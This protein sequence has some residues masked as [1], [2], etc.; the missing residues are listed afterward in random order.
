[1]HQNYKSTRRRF[2]RQAGLAALG[3]ST[4]GSSIFKLN[5]LNAAAL[6]N[7]SVMNDDYKALVCL[8]KSGGNDSFNMLMPRGNAEYNEYAT[9]RSNLAIPQN[10]ILAINPLTSDGKQYGVHPSMSGVQQLFENQ[11]L[12][13]VSNIGT[14]IAPIN[15]EQYFNGSV[16]V[17]LGLFS[18]ADQIQQWQTAHPHLRSPVGWG[19][20]VADLLSDMNDNESISMNVSMSGT[21]VFQYGQSTIEFSANNE[22]GAEGIYGYGEPWGV[23]PARTMAIDQMLDHDYED[24]YQNTYV[25]VLRNAKDAS[26]EFRDAVA[27]IPE[28]QTNF[29]A[30]NLS[31]S[32]RMIA[33][34]IAARDILGFKRQIFFVNVGG[35]DNHDELL[36][37]QQA[38]LGAVSTALSEFAEVLEEIDM[39]D[40]VTTFTIS[41]FG[42]TL[43]SNGNGTDHAWGG[44]VM[45]MGGAV[46]GGEMFGTFPSLELGN[47]LEIYG[48]V[49][50]PTTSA[51]LYFAELALWFGVPASELNTIFP[52]LGNFY[53]VSG[54]GNP[55][56]LIE[57]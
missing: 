29:S 35:W 43:T 17:P 27:S 23:D 21:N 24:I 41:E 12:S 30:G 45:A 4:V 36:N 34:A 11:K 15:K 56:G 52:N 16:P 50:L 25:N 9:T 20:R 14:M 26:I 54:G 5:A 46:N 40:C 19:G 37:N 33:K 22:S 7:S 57:Y 28:F 10:E 49:L 1:M 3:Y 13:F 48:G 38:L 32:F 51:D 8:F 6:S 53:D 31:Q 44:N 55:L 39:F 18:H 2:L 42:R 47:P